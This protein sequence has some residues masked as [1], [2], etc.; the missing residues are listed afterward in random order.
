MTAFEGV[1]LALGA[2]FANKLRSALTLLGMVIGVASVVAMISVGAGAEQS[3]TAE[4]NSIG[5]NIVYVQPRYDDEEHPPAM[6]KQRDLHALA[7]NATSLTGLTP[8]N[9]ID[10]E[11]RLGRKRIVAAVAGTG[12]RF[13]ELQRLGL[14]EGRFFSQQEAAIGARVIVLGPRIREDLVG[15]GN[16]LGVRVRV[17][18]Q[19]YLVIGVMVKKAE[20]TIIQDGLTGNSM[21]YIPLP[22]FQRLTG[23]IEVP[24]VMGA[25]I[26]PDYLRN[27]V[28]QVEATI[29]RL[30]GPSHGFQIGSTAEIMA[31][32][33]KVVGIFTVVLGCLGGISLLVGGIG[34]MNIMLV[35]V[36]E[37]TR[38]IGIRR[39]VGAKRRDI[40]FQF[41]VE[42]V[43]LAGCGG[44][45]GVLCGATLAVLFSLVT[46]VHT[47]ITGSAILLAFGC[48]GAIGVLFGLYPAW[49]AA[50]LDPIEAL[51]YE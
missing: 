21:A 9:R 6:L 12:P 13:I 48:V 10:G 43:T 31:S 15:D 49:R 47:A 50:R 33:N 2:I 27:A 7:E 44:L 45:I 5:T 26:R 34:V 3:V 36:T 17:N 41:L 4:F 29:A 32:V 18:G 23:A 14:A 51:R 1:R 25:P 24:F 19:P 40:M 11:I 37:R 16:I 22:S 30:Y 28:G 8:F 20:R 38:E 35:A 46:P 39:A 42:S